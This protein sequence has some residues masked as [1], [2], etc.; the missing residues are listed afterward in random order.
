M[1]NQD[2]N[3]LEN[4]IHMEE[5]IISNSNITD[6][7]FLLAMNDHLRILELLDCKKILDFKP[8]GNLLNLNRFRLDGYKEL[9]NIDFVSTLTNL[10]ILLINASNIENIKAVEQLIN[11][12]AFSLA[13]LSTNVLNGD[14]EPITKL[15]KLSM[16][17]IKPRKHYSHKVVK[18]WNWDNF[19]VPDIQLVKK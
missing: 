12:K 5:L 6:L 8:I 18:E 7:S 11:L 9:L 3:R 17:M 4:L 19:D 15:Q 16:F 14:L 1:K 13:G 10:E 2:E